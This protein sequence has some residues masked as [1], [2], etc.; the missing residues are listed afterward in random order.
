LSLPIGPLSATQAAEL[1][2]D[3]EATGRAI[4]MLDAW[5][6]GWHRLSPE[7]AI[8]ALTPLQQHAIT[9]VASL[10]SVSFFFALRAS[11]DAKRRGL[12]AL[13]ELWGIR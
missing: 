11:N 7:A 10:V 8:T 4:G 1:E 5:L 13:A 6:P 12:E 3:S 2:I 9:G